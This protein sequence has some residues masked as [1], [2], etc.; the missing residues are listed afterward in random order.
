MKKISIFLFL[1]LVSAACSAVETKKAQ[2]IVGVSKAGLKN[3][4]VTVA[5]TN[6]KAVSL[7]IQQNSGILDRA[8]KCQGK[9]G[10]VV[11]DQRGDETRVRSVNCP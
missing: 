9:Q 1:L 4:H 8:E 3:G 2:G 6:G 11:Y 5:P 7:G 10:T